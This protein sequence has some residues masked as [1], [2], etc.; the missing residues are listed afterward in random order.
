[1]SEI[2]LMISHS[3]CPGCLHGIVTN[4]HS[5]CAGAQL[6]KVADLISEG[7]V[8]VNVDKTFPLK[9]AA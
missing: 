7:K 8:K 2:C 3:G 1:M 9:D 6:Q 4:T 5:S